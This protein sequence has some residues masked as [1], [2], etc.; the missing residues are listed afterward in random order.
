MRALKGFCIVMLSAAGLFAQYRGSATPY[1]TGGFGSVLYPGG[2]TATSSNIVRF[3]TNVAHPGGGGPRL[4][5]PYSSG[6]YR[7]NRSNGGYI[8]PYSYAYPVYVGNYYDPSAAGYVDPSAVPPPSAGAA[9]PGT[10]GAP[11]IINIG[12]PGPAAAPPGAPGGPGG[13]ATPPE[14]YQQNAPPQDENAGAEPTHYL[15]ALKDHTI[16]S[17]VAYWVDGNTLHYFT[18]GNVHNQVSVSLVDR[19]LTERLNKETGLQVNLPK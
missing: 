16:Y 12:V 4:N 14:A 13:P 18:S 15:I 9:G 17:A 10:S 8:Y 1:I 6:Y 5:V 3:Q 2:T 7:S 19:E 11:I